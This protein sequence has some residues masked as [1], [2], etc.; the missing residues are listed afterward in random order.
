MYGP[1]MRW[2]VLGAACSLVG[3]MGGCGGTVHYDRAQYCLGTIAR[4]SYSNSLVVKRE[5]MPMRTREGGVSVEYALLF[6]NEGAEPAQLAL[7]EA[8]AK[9]DGEPELATV[10]C[11]SHGVLPSRAIQVAA[12]QRVRVDCRLGLTAA[13][14]LEARA[15]DRQLAF[16]LPVLSGGQVVELE[17]I[18]RLKLEDLS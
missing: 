5:V 11:A 17:F 1:L 3:M 16:W 2:R 8:Y 6:Q 4:L 14:V 9:L 13:G 10:R 15:S 7:S 12:G 18:Y